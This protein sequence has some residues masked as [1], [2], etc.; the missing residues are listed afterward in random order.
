M[1]SLNPVVCVSNTPWRTS[2]P[3][4]RQQLP[5]YLAHH[6]RVLY[7]SP[8]SLGQLMLGRVGLRDYRGSLSEACPGLYVARSPQFLT[9]VKGQV[10][11]LKQIDQVLRERKI[12]QCMKALDVGKPILWLYFP[13][14]FEH[15]I[16]RL[17]EAVT[18]YHCTDDYV[19]YAETLGWDVARINAEEQAL[20]KRADFVF[21]TS[22]PI[23]EKHKKVNPRTFLMPNVAE[24][25]FFRRVAEGTVG[26]ADDVRNIP[27]P[28]AGFIGAVDR[29]KL[30]V[31]LIDNVA[32]LRP[33]WSF[34]FVGP[35]GAGDGTSLSQLP[36]RDNVYYL[37]RRS[38]D[39][40]PSY[41]A[42]FDVCLIPYQINSYTAGVF[43]LKFWEYLAAGKPVAMTP[44][45]ALSEHYDLAYVAG[46]A[47]EFARSLNVALS[48]GDEPSLIKHRVEIA[49]QNSWEK[50]A[51][52]IVGILRAHLGS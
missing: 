14:S 31:E 36:Q 35:I 21:V 15:L 50:R 1:S 19:G 23:Y 46:G 12:K 34:V 49:S 37:G 18:C 29:Y 41:I 33:D 3:T 48:Q 47:D 45:P 30:D 17:G 51:E 25:A 13:P 11:P 27:R 4:N 32:A 44:L 20:V 42:G 24:T 38:Y 52:E 43:P 6:T 22:R 28:V 40:L 7:I 8:F 39:V 10:W 9:M 16:G 2:L 5:R 26:T